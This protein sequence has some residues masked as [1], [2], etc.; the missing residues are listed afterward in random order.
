MDVCRSVAVV[1]SGL[2]LVINYNCTLLDRS[3][4][5]LE[6]FSKSVTGLRNPNGFHN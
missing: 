2:F 1:K 6:R 4:K 5:Y 3:L